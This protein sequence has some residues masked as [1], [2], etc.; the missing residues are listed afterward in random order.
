MLLT[1]ITHGVLLLSIE[2]L[3]LAL[4]VDRQSASN[5]TTRQW[6]G[7][8]K[9]LARCSKLCASYCCPAGFVEVV[10]PSLVRQAAE[11]SGEGSDK[12]ALPLQGSLLSS[13]AGMPVHINDS[14]MTQTSAC[15]G[16]RYS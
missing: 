5:R 11:G 16:L 14:N 10:D 8:V 12:N 4:C 2:H 3:L 15:V 7:E 1:H 13:E 6:V 9:V